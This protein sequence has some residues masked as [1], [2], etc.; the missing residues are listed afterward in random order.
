MKGFNFSIIFALL[1]SLVFA[2]S[3]NLL[4]SNRGEARTGDLITDQPVVMTHEDIGGV[5]YAT[6][7]L[8]ISYDP[9]V[10][11]AP[12]DSAIEA[13][14]AEVL[15]RYRIINAV[16]IRLPEGKDIHKAIKSFELVK[17]VT[18]VS[19]DRINHLH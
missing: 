7:R 5:E 8:I 11:T 4:R 3:C 17:G 2:S 19:R 13:F 6:D 9:E 18:S 16:A 12:L 10:G 15:Y 1:V 14:H